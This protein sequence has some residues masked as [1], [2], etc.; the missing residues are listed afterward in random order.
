M[1]TERLKPARTRTCSHGTWIG[2]DYSD[3][4]IE[5]MNAMDRYKREKRRP[6][7]SWSEVL[8]VLVGLG[9]RKESGA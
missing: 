4:E 7:P 5:F 6:F 8:A 2:A 9:Y 1:S 3:D